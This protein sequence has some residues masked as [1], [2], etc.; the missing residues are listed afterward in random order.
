V[1]AAGAGAEA[2]RVLRETMAK[3][4]VP[5]ASYLAVVVQDV[6][7]MG[8]FLGGHALGSARG[9]ARIEVIPDEHRRLSHVLGSLAGRQ[10][11]A[12]RGPAL[13]GVAVYA[14]GDDLLALT[15]AATALQAAEEAGEMIP[16]QLPHARSAACVIG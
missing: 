7:S 13:L 5:L 4:G 16:P 8:R 6:D 15:P 1:A 12:L 9:K 10:A 14:G 11:R 2:A 3:R